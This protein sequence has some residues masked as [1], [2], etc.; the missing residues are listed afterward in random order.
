MQAPRTHES[1]FTIV[2]VLVAALILTIAA[3]ATFGVLSAA[4]KNTERAKATQVA[5]DRAQQEVEKLRTLSN[6]ELA[7]TT[8]PAP[9]TTA[10]DPGYRVNASLGTYALNRTTPS[11]SYRPM[12]VNGGSLY[13]GGV[14][15][16]GVVNP[17]PIPFSSGTV[18]GRVYRYVVWRNDEKCPETSCPGTQ[19]YKQIVVAV[20]LD[21]PPNQSGERGYVEVQSN[22]VDPQDSPE[23]DPIAGANGVVTAQQ[24]FLSDTTCSASGETSR[25]DITGDHLLHN[26]MGKCSNGL[27]N[28]TTP[29]APDT[30]LLGGPPD[31]APE[32]ESNP[33]RYDYSN[34]FYLEPTPDTD[35]GVQIRQG[36]TSGCFYTP[37]GTTNPQAQVH[38][39]VSDPMAAEFKL[40]GKVTLKFFT[41]TLND[42][43]YKG[44]ICV[45]LFV[46]NKEETTDTMLADKTGGAS[47]WTYSPGGTG[48][49]PREA[50]TEVG[51][52][53]TISSASLA[54]VP[55]EARLGLAITVD[56]AK[57]DADAIPI[58]YDHPN[59]PSR[60]EV[61]TTTPIDGG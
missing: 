4:T 6:K 23:G 11:G 39:W 60:L 44:G 35:K 52:P 30:L 15:E 41:R 33:L 3:M 17:G 24:F 21:T 25:E 5:L 18:H 43:L 22:F 40:S 55:K 27:Q 34:D 31:P 61:E 28:G 26:T 14:V 59:E 9:S 54:A 37:T 58:M 10:L 48:Y 53:M 56:P 32:D 19:D 12:V 38:R 42:A 29:G 1:G 45:Y 47:Y 7:M 50:W 13:G 2:E 36:D 51:V 20:K 16:G 8:T 46:R 49:W 57:T